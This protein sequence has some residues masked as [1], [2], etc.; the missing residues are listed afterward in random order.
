MYNLTLKHVRTIIV[1]V[2]TMRI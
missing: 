1:L 2:E